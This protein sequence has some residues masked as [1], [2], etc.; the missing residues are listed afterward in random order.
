ML[1]ILGFGIMFNRIELS[2]SARPIPTDIALLL[3]LLGGIGIRIL[4]CPGIIAVA[5]SAINRQKLSTPTSQKSA[6]NTLLRR[7]N[8]KILFNIMLAN[9]T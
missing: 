2:S 1:Y 7:L 9:N 8:P 4:S 6:K 5:F 3:Q